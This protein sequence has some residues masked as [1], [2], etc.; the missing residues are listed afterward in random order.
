[1]TLFP[2]W[3][4]R[5]SRKLLFILLFQYFKYIECEGVPEKITS[6]SSIHVIVY[7]AVSAEEGE[8]LRY[9]G[10]AYIKELLK[11]AYAL[12]AFCKLL[13]NHYPYGMGYDF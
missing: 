6:E 5:R 3:A 1:M 11:V 7:G 10:L 8:V 13:E 9:I 12:Y 2:Y 4:A